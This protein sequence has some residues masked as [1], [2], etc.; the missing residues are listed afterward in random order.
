MNIELVVFDMAGTTIA[1]NG[2]IAA[3]FQTA[4]KHFGYDVPI[5]AIKTVMGYKKT[6]AIKMMLNLY[7]PSA[8]ISEELLEEIHTVFLNKMAAHY[9]DV[10]EIEI[11]PYAT[12]IFLF[13]KSKGIKVALDT[14]FTKQI[15]DIIID[16]LGWLKNNLID[17]MVCSD[18]VPKGRPYSYMIEKIMQQVGVT[19]SQ[20]VIKVGDTEVDVNEGLNANCFYSI[21]ITTGAFT[22]QQ[23]LLHKPSFIIEHLS[24]LEKIICP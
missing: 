1:D 17:S 5:D 18:E 14:G 3:A 19:D 8:I 2:E 13:L 11:L 10:N 12:E 4:L 15:A 24:E 7:G 9:C 22:R 6:K 16:K 23:L 21:G 20:K